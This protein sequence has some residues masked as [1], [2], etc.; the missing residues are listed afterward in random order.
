MILHHG[1]ATLT[2]SRPLQSSTILANWVA[3][4]CKTLHWKKER[5]QVSVTTVK[6]VSILSFAATYQRDRLLTP[7][8]LTVASSASA[9]AEVSAFLKCTA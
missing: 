2:D 8:F 3:M 9:A 7:L 5:K 6:F 4:L 1:Q